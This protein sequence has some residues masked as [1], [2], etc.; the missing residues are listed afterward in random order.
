ME[1]IADT[2]VLIDLWRFRDKPSRIADLA[3]KVGGPH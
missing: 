1:F 2:T 3:E